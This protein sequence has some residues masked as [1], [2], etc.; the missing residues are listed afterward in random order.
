MFEAE[1]LDVINEAL[2]LPQIGDDDEGL[3]R[4]A[5]DALLRMELRGLFGKHFAPSDLEKTFPERDRP[6]IEKSDCL[7]WAKAE[8]LFLGRHKHLVHACRA[9]T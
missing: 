5:D 1:I 9:A 4:A 7:G 2:S 3:I 6:T 8:A